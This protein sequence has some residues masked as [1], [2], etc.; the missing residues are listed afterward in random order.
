MLDFKIIRKHKNVAPFE[1]QANDADSTLLP[2]LIRDTEIAVT[3]DFPTY[4][5]IS[6]YDVSS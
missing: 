6:A 1:L 2:I 5:F 4:L 3:V